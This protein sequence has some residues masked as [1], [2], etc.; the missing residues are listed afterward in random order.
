MQAPRVA[1]IRPRAP[2]HRC[3]HALRR[4]NDSAYTGAQQPC[5]RC[6][7]AIPHDSGPQ[8]EGGHLRHAAHAQV[9]ALRSQ[10]RGAQV[11]QHPGHAE[12]F[13]ILCPDN[14]T[15]QRTVH[16]VLGPGRFGSVEP[17]HRRVG[18]TSR[19]NGGACAQVA[20]NS[21]RPTEGTGLCWHCNADGTT[22][23]QPIPQR[24]RFGR[25]LGVHGI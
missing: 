21:A 6:V 19:T 25:W 11:F 7:H 2:A 22:D 1:T 3:A 10:G 5:Q 9:P 8:A 12:Q 13:G 17:F 20:T 4:R 15:G 23:R 24:R 16:P 18:R 14:I